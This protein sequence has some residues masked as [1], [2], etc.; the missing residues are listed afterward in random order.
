LNAADRQTLEDAVIVL[1]GLLEDAA[2]IP[3]PGASR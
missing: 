3:R 1:R 2:T